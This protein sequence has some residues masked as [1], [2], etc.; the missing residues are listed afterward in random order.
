M[1]IY[2]GNITHAGI[3]SVAGKELHLLGQ[4]SQ[5]FNYGFKDTYDFEEGINTVL[6]DVLFDAGLILNDDLRVSTILGSSVDWIYD[7]KSGDDSWDS[8]GFGESRDEMYFDDEYWQVLKE[9]HV[10]WAPGNFL[11]RV[12]KQVVTW[13]LIDGPDILNQ[14]N[15]QDGRRGDTETEFE[16]SVIPIWML[17]AEYNP[18]IYTSFINDLNIQFLFNPNADFIPSQQQ[19]P[20]TETGGIFSIPAVG[21]GFGSFDR[22]GTTPDEWDSDGYEYGVQVQ[23]F[24]RESI[25]NL[26]YFKGIAN[27]YVSETDMAAAGENIGNNMAAGIGPLPFRFDSSG[28][29]HIPIVTHYPDQEFFGGYISRDMQSWT[30]MPGKKT[31]ILKFEF[32]Y[33]LDKEFEVNL[34]DVMEGA[35]TFMEKD[36]FT[37]GAGIEWNINI[38]YITAQGNGV[39]FNSSYVTSHILGYDDRLDSIKND[40]FF[41]FIVNSLYMSARLKPEF[42]WV[43]D[44]EARENQYMFSAEYLYNSDIM[45]S[46]GVKIYDGPSPVEDSASI[47]FSQNKDHAFLKITYQF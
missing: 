30:F 40:T 34:D 9:L 17:R 24:I 46:G 33:E 1:A 28:R 42:S 29:F 14:I 36:M 15:P 13:G 38:P 18:G 47:G 12:G 19:L 5:T 6:T 44:L 20:G 43:R 8:K 21:E 2:N 37:W 22:T 39:T 32:A 25:V 31:P 45:I 11:F 10:T 26:N 41:V 3:Y 16:T 4:I 27:E 23:A 35:P 7:F